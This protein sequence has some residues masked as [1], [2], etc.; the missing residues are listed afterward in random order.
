MDPIAVLYR[1]SVYIPIYLYCMYIYLCIKRERPINKKGRWYK[2][3][4]S[5]II[6]YH[7]TRSDIKSIHIHF[8]LIYVPTMYI[9]ATCIWADR[10]LIKRRLIASGRRPF[11]CVSI[12]ICGGPSDQIYRRLRPKRWNLRAARTPIHIH[13]YVYIYHIY[14]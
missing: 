8:V 1:K 6:V 3:F 5:V 4:S 11:V 12:Y 9:D 2:S 10:K 14:I 7:P 13:A